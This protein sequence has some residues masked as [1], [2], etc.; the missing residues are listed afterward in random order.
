MKEREYLLIA[1]DMDGTLLNSGQEIT[2]RAGRAM[3]E[4]M[5]R[6]K[7]VVFSTGRCIREMEAFP[8]MKY[9]ICEI[10]RASCRER[11]SSPV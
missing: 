2:P 7:Q 10:G 5:R 4:I 6:G 8:S 1:L 9:L 3:E 11:V